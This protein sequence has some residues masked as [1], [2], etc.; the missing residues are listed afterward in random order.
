MA[1]RYAAQRSRRD[2]RRRSLPRLS[3]VAPVALEERENDEIDDTFDNDEEPTEG[4]PASSIASASREPAVTVA[5]R[6]PRTDG[7]RSITQQGRG[8]LGSAQAS[9]ITRVDYSYVKSDLR[10][11]AMTAAVMLVLLILLNVVVQNLVH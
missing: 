1:E 11:I 8:A 4:A 7:T 9:S 6:L 2:V 3:D 5:R 10:R